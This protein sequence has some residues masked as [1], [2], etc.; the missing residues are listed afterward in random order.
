MFKYKHPELGR[1]QKLDVRKG[2]VGTV[3]VLALMMLLRVLRGAW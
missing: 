1:G 2:A 3:V